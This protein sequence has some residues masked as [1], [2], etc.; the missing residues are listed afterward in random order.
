MKKSCYKGFSAEPE[1]QS[2]C[3]PCFSAARESAGLQKQS[4]NRH[5]AAKT[6]LSF[7]TGLS[8]TI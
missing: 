8:I 1:K 7:S 4:S 6:E 2:T 3:S 5:V